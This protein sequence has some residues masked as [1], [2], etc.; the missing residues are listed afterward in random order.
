MT[1]TPRNGFTLVELLVVIT[2]VGILIALLLPA[3]QAARES[4]R[5]MQCTNNLKQIGLALH[6]Y[7]AQYGRLP[8]SG[9]AMQDDYSPLA[10][11]LP[12]VEQTNLNELIDFRISMG[13]I[14]R[15]DLPVALRPAAATVVPLFLCPSDGEKPLH[16]LTL[17]SESVRYAASNY[18]MN[19]GSGADGKTAIMAKTDG[20][21]YCGAKLRLDD[22]QDGTSHTLAFTESLIGPCDSPDPTPTPDTQFYRAQLASPS[23]LLAAAAAADA[24]GVD[25]VL[26]SVSKWDGGRLVYWLRGYPPGGPVL[27]GRFTPNSPI[28]DLIGGSGRL[29]AARSNHRGSVNACFADGSV[30][31]LSN[32]VQPAV[33][34]ALWTIKG[35]EIASEF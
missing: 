23:G 1:P 16:D 33:W 14:A 25:A 35:G 31:S 28:P 2:I 11:L 17:V 26:S 18:A 15:V 13:H 32:F 24:G 21:C 19:G 8:N 12:F 4:A 34:H 20:L 6:G 22:V 29:C 9:N 5:H 7:A 3:V 30:R 10:R 27:I